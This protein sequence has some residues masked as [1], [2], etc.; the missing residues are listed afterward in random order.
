VELQV[1]VRRQ[2]QAQDQHV[3]C[4]ARQ[5]QHPARQPEHRVLAGRRHARLHHAVGLRDRAAG[6]DVALR[7]L[8]VRQGLELVRAV[9][10]LAFE[11]AALAGAAGAVAAA[12]GQAHALADGGGEYGFVGL[13][14]EGD[15]GGLDLDLEAHR[16]RAL[17]LLRRLCPRP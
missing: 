3:G 7:L 9:H 5:A 4:G 1:L 16:R 10:H 15:V 17:K 12:I 6:E 2:L 11:Q 8:L 13:D 14:L